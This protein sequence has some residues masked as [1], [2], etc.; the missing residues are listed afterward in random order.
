MTGLELEREAAILPE[1]GHR[2][3]WRNRGAPVTVRR[4]DPSRLRR[5]ESVDRLAASP[6]SPAMMHYVGLDVS[7]KETSICVVDERRRA[8]KEGGRKA[9]IAGV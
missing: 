1:M 4:D 6:W 9:N 7:F 8:L 5:I 3:V 2:V